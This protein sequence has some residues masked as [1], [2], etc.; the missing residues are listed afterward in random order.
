MYEHHCKYAGVHIE[1]HKIHLLNVMSSV[2]AR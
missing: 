2:Y 1:V